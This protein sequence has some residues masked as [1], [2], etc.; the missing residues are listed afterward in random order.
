M[1]IGRTRVSVD[2]L[3]GT[4]SQLAYYPTRLTDAQLQALTA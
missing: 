1:N 4:I 3:N 2:Y